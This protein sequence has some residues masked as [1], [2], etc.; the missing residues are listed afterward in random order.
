MEEK[1][2]NEV[3]RG[4]GRPRKLPCEEPKIPKIL[5]RPRKIQYEEP[6]IPKKL[7]RPKLLPQRWYCPHC[8]HFFKTRQ[9]LETHSG[10]C[11][12]VGNNDYKDIKKA[13][14]KSE[15]KYKR[16]I[17]GLNKE[18]QK[19]KDENQKLR[20]KVLVLSGKLDVIFT[21]INTPKQFKFNTDNYEA[22]NL[23]QE[24]F[25][26]I[27][28]EKY[29][30]EI[31]SKGLEGCLLIYAMY[32][33]NGKDGIIQAG[34]FDDAECEL[35]VCDKLTHQMVKLPIKDLWKKAYS[36]K[37]LKFRLNKFSD[38]MLYGDENS[39]LTK[40]TVQL[41]NTTKNIFLHFN[42]F[43]DVL[44]PKLRGLITGQERLTNWE[45]EYIKEKSFS[46]SEEEIEDEEDY[47]EE[48]EEGKIENI[49]EDEEN[50]DDDENDNEE[51]NEDEENKESE[52]EE[53]SEEESNEE[54]DEEEDNFKPKYCNKQGYM[55]K[56]PEFRKAEYL[57]LVKK[58]DS[59]YEEGEE[60]DYYSS[61][62][63][64]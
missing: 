20:E 30:Y 5:G 18:N 29:V 53:E 25:D 23:T 54:E 40:S 50:S 56:S 14:L 47:D 63:S 11:K 27:V 52:E 12:K 46:E 16:D 17:T 28:E 59:D 35:K 33:S 36:S 8:R 41:V 61:D 21:S 19:L 22:I 51:S 1:K 31:F 43:K 37:I 3:K 32:L 2:D 64:Y 10:K 15:S 42:T 38:R 55:I 13:L 26:R 62:E 44:Y 60:N 24:R 57:R 48:I 7:G 39:T 49:E 45:R 4:R 6:E 58:D 34:I 9:T